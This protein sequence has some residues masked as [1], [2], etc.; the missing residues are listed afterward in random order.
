MERRIY[1]L[2][3]NIL[4]LLLGLFFYRVMAQLIVNF[5]DVPFLPAFAQWHSASLPYPLLVLSQV[6]IIVIFTRIAWA[7]T[8]GRVRPRYYLG[9]VLL[10]L[11]GIYFSLM[12]TRLVVGSFFLNAHPWWDKPIPSFFHLVLASFLVVVGYFHWCYGRPS[13]SNN[14]KHPD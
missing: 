1:R 11:G 4:W 8:R 10:V 7:F 9:R 5:V 12:V 2:Y 6:I 13:V 14:D 3:S